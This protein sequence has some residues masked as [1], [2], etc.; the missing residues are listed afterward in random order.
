MSDFN[1]ETCG[2]PILENEKGVYITA[3][4]HYPLEELTKH[5]RQNYLETVTEIYFSLPIIREMRKKK[6]DSE[7]KNDRRQM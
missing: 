7:G 3:C 5:N 2:L 1:C 6:K 4:K